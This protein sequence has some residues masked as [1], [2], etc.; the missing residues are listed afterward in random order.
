MR[1]SWSYSDGVPIL[2]VNM[3]GFVSVIKAIGN[4]PNTFWGITILYSSM[5][6]SVHFN[7]EI[8]YYFAGVGST[9]L[10]INHVQSAMHTMTTVDSS[11]AIKV[12]SNASDPTG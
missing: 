6:M 4:L 9:L 8:G 7:A 12:E 5:Y 11:P 10:G 2:A 1:S 3:S